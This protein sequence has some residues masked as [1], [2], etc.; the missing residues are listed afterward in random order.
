VNSI[1]KMMKLKLERKEAEFPLFWEK[2]KAEAIVDKHWIE[3]KLLT[4]K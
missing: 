4:K 3:E 2:I 1:Q